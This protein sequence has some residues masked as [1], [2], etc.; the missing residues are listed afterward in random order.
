MF[1]AHDK[2]HRGPRRIEPRLLSPTHYQVIEGS[3][4]SPKPFV[5]KAQATVWSG[6]GNFLL[7]DVRVVS[8]EIEAQIVE[9]DRQELEIRKRRDNLLKDNF[10][11]FR[12]ATPDDFEDVRPGMTETEARAK[13][14]L[15]D[16][17]KCAETH[18]RLKSLSGVL[19]KI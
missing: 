4:R 7:K 16:R 8:P 13:L 15:V 17:S 11:T 9:L 2:W 14:K 10:L 19:S 1:V 12:L 3:S 6:A 5:E 18:R